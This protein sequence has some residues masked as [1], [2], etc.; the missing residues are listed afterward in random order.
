MD[1]ELVGD[2]DRSEFESELA[3]VSSSSSDSVD[4]SSSSSPDS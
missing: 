3:D 1:L 2:W 4:L